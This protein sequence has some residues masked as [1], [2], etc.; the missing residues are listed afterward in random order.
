[1]MY[2][3]TD[4]LVYYYSQFPETPTFVN[5]LFEALMNC[6]YIPQTLV[7]QTVAPIPSPVPQLVIPPQPVPTL[8]KPQEKPRKTSVSEDVLTTRV[9]AEVRNNK[10]KDPFIMHGQ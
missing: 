4:Y 1:M 2:F 3:N 7:E 8:V 5:V 6:S 9:L 10:Q